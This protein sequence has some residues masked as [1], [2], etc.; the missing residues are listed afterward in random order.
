MLLLEVTWLSH[1][2]QGSLTSLG[3]Q[4]LLETQ[5]WVSIDLGVT[6]GLG[7]QIMGALT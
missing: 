4:C 6:K 5:D 7:T 1:I 2:N 3:L